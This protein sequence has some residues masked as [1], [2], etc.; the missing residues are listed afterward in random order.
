MVN[1]LFDVST[2]IPDDDYDLD[3]T[4][5]RMLTIN[6]VLLFCSF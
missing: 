5:N 3:K 1:I 4:L 6:G 2:R